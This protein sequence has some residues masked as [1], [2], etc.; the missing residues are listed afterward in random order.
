P[1]EP[2]PKEAAF[3]WAGPVTADAVALTNHPWSFTISGLKQHLGLARLLVVND[4]AASAL[5]VPRLKESERFVIGAGA[6]VADA[7]IG[8][9]GPGSGLGMAALV[10]TT[11]GWMALS[12]EGGHATMA[13]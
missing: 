4:F 12:S 6:P 10:P 9:L 7:P 11:N 5:A 3:A 8:V 1:P 13:P 2:A